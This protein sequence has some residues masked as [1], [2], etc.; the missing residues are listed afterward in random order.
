MNKQKIIPIVLLVLSIS[1]ISG[2]LSAQEKTFFDLNGEPVPEILHN[3]I[4]VDLTDIP[5][6]EVLSI[7]S[8]K[9]KFYLSYNENI[10]PENHKISLKLENI[11]SV[12]V[13]RKALE[14]TDIDF[15]VSQS[16]QVVL[17]DSKFIFASKSRPKFTLS[18]YLTDEKTGEILVG[19]NIYIE[20]LKTGCT[21]NVYGYYSLTVPSGYF[22]IKYSYMGY[23]TEE[24]SLNLNRNIKRDVE[25]T[26]S[27]FSGESVT[28]T[29][30]IE[31][32]N[33]K[34]A[35][36]GTINITPGKLTYVP[37]LFG[38][39]DILKTL[40]LLPGITG[41]REGDCGFY[42]RGSSSTQNLV[43]LDEAPVYNAFHFLGFFSVFNSDAIKNLKVFKGPA[44]PKYGGKLSSVL[45]IQMNDGN[46]KEYN[47]SGGI[48]LIFSRLALEGPLAGDKG[49]FL[50]SARRTYID[51]FM[52]LQKDPD[53]R[54]TSLFFYDYNLKTNYKL[55]ENDRIFLSGYF[56][57]DALGF[58]EIFNIYWGNKTAT[59]RWSHLFND[60]LFLN[61]SLIFSNFK[62]EINVE[63]E[64]EEYEYDYESSVHMSSSI[65]DYTL[66]ED[67]QY[68][69]DSRNT[70]NFGLQYSYHSFKPISLAID[71]QYEDDDFDMTIGKR[72]AHESAVYLSHEFDPSE[73][74]KFDYG[75]RYSM[76]NVFGPGDYYVFDYSDEMQELKSYKKGN[77]TYSGLEPRFTMNYLF[78]ESSSVKLGYA[79]NFQYIH[80]FS[81]SMSG[82]PLDI[83]Q[84]CSET[85]KPQR[86]DLVSVGYF[87]NFDSNKYETSVEV[88][89]KDLRN[90]IEYKNGANIFLGN[91]I[92]SE[93]TFGKGW[94]YGVEFFVRKNF[95]KLTGW[96]GYTISKSNRKFYEIN[97]NKSFP[98]K[99]DRTHDF[100][101]VGIYNLNDRW[102]FS[103]NW[104]Y[105]TGDAYTIP[106][107]RYQIAE[108]TFDLFTDRNSFRLPA[109]HRLDLGITYK[110]KGGNSLNFSLYNAYGRK[111]IFTLI[112]RRKEDDPNTRE[113][114]KLSLFSFI[115]SLTYNFTF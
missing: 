110:T 114:V 20:K 115:P 4:S 96:L 11:P 12:S 109:Y 78:N 18:G 9:G 5:L 95:G 60:R 102:T 69:L 61:S 92:E 113:I 104:V 94:A 90:Q 31:N 85:I 57:K 13:L 46:S 108:H 55:G 79:R 99:F 8:A 75:L 62:Y 15:V 41:G 34:S 70:L 71:E 84:P 64:D 65:R 58:E 72:N 54:N 47:W 17:V 3:K 45:D 26:E 63:G 101:A 2:S 29:A 67:F 97:N 44:P 83:W 53:V 86:S 68:F 89:Y 105:F 93:L 103:F 80:M 77:I 6:R 49:S 39:Q 40:H 87:R 73:K 74:L 28:I 32:K 35:E 76:F 56:G 107:G 21:S 59:L 1:L 36:M 16:G 23:K 106:V 66:K 38:E 7:I 81:R 14:S 30:E 52:K 51:L 82:T 10:I 19:A 91:F 43:L 24:V 25:L 42:V 111:N 33:V 88:Y 100:S 112:F 22:L 27:V 48:G 98:A 50:L 37:V